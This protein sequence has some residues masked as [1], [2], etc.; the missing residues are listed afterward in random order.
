MGKSR[1]LEEILRKNREFEREA[2]YN[3]CDRWYE[4]CSHEKQIRCKLYQDEFEQK[5]T[6]IAHGRGLD[7][8]EITK[9]VM[10]RQFEDM[11]EVLAAAEEEGFEIDL[12]EMVNSDFEEIKEHI[13][14]VENN[15]SA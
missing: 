13:K 11:G 2:P 1:R 15:P 8:P 6:C 14:F 5:I 3:F 10:K 12:D 9:E 4:R 7:N